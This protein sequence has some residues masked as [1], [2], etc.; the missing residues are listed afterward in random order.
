[1]TVA[2][3]AAAVLARSSLETG[4]VLSVGLTWLN[5]NKNTKVELLVSIH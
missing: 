4:S 5:Q 1:M 2:K 3:S